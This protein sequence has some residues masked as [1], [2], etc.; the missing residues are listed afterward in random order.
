[1]EFK[2]SKMILYLGLILACFLIAYFLIWLSFP[3]VK[4]NQKELIKE[5]KTL[6]EK[7]STIAEFQRISGKYKKISKNLKII[8]QILPSEADQPLILIQL[9]ALA[10][11][12]KVEIT[13][14]S[15]SPLKNSDK[16]V[17]ILPVN[18]NAKG[19]YLALKNFLESIAT[20]LNIMEVQNLTL[21]VEEKVAEEKVKIYSFSLE[22]DVYTQELPKVEITPP[23]QPGE[24]TTTK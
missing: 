14:I 2:G 6:E 24:E 1:M 15:F 5:R 22:I 16:G 4:N 20:N 11:Q 3:E 9:G 10:T 18:I 8:N 19:S 13:N 23:S 12:N 7:E 17:G 21:E